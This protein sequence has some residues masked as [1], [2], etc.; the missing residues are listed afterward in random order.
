MD[1][2]NEQMNREF[3]SAYIYKAM[4]GYIADQ[5]YDGITH[6]FDKQVEEETQHG[7]KIKNFLQEVGYKVAYR[8]FEQP[9]ND[10]ASIIDVFQ[11]A[12]EHEQFITKSIDDLVNAAREA[13]DKR[14]EFFLQWFVE[15]QVEEEAT[16]EKHIVRLGRIGDSSAGMYIF[17]NELAMR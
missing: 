12:L 17:N 15:E 7:N 10:F 5:D 1:Q 4:A 8:A 3:E 13:D 16:F 11:K 6:F 9:E 2:L 14:V